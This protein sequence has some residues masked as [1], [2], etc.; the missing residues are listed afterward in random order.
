MQV[1]SRV[2]RVQIR[3]MFHQAI[4]TSSWNQRCLL[5]PKAVDSVA[6]SQLE[7]HLREV[8]VRTWEDAC[9][10]AMGR[11]HALD[12]YRLGSEFQLYT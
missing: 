6:R 9:L 11:A 3:M 2:F 7:P 5:E 8:G 1:S 12:S 10:S 4:F